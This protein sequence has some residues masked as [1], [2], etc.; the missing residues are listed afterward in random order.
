MLI[1][2]WDMFALITNFLRNKVQ[3]SG[4]F[5]KAA[6][7]IILTRLRIRIGMM[8][9]LKQLIRINLW[10]ILLPVLVVHLLHDISLLIVSLQLHNWIIQ[11][12]LRDLSIWLIKCLWILVVICKW[13][14]IKPL[15][16]SVVHIWCSWDLLF[17]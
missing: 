5:N 11:I 13:A 15:E 9:E 1:E 7:R 10:Y 2:N 17:I 14:V 12:I 8:K 6:Q 16:S 3:I 4:I